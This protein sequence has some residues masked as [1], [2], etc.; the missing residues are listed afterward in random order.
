M[1]EK[2]LQRISVEP[3]RRL[4]LELVLHYHSTLDKTN[5]TTRELRTMAIPQSNQEK[6]LRLVQEGK[7]LSKIAEEDF[8]DIDYWEIWWTVWEG[9]ERSARG[10][11]KM[12]TNRLNSLI[13]AG[14]KQDRQ[15]LIDEISDLVSY[16]Y[17]NH[18]KISEKLGKIRKTLEN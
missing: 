13:E 18:K 12:I 3:K 14:K 7:P 11:K 5:S 17:K 6:I 4:K 9:G 2:S 8:P 15:Q 16:L 10:V 1:A